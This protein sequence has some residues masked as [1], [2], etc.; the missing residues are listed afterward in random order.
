MQDQLKNVRQIEAGA[1]AFAAIL[2]DESVVSWGVADFG[3]DSSAVQDQ[4]KNVQQI[5]ANGDAFAAI[6]GDGSVIT[7]GN[8][9]SGGDSSAVQGQLKNVHH[10][11]PAIFGGWVCRHLGPAKLCC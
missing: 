9:V 2:G 10:A 6:L 8:E 11:Y 4:L 5:Q 1:A 3:G 7:W